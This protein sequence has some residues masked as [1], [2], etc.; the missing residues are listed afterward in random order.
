MFGAVRKALLQEKMRQFQTG[1]NTTIIDGYLG[2]VFKN[3]F[4]YVH[5]PHA[6]NRAIK[7]IYEACN[8]QEIERA[9][10]ERREPILI[11]HFSCHSLRH[12]FCTR[13]CENETDLKII[14][15]IMGH[16]DISTTMNVYN[17]ATKERKQASFARL[18]GKIKIC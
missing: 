12:T 1:S 16:A 18:E 17:E 11:P 4:G 2:F 15:E 5:N 8:K 9:A 10:K 3:R 14:Q 13:F 7:R 6:I